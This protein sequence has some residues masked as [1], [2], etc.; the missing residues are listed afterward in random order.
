MAGRESERATGV[1][2]KITSLG[3]EGS[4]DKRKSDITL[5]RYTITGM[6]FVFVLC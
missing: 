3:V 4:V 6:F 2:H 5:I 1:S